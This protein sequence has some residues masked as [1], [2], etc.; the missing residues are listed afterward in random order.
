MELSNQLY[1]VTWI[2]IQLGIFSKKWF[3]WA[4]MLTAGLTIF[5]FSEVKLVILNIT[6]KTKINKI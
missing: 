1:S 2:G 5:I 3:F 6:V 4:Q